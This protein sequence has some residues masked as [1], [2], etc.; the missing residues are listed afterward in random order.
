MVAAPTYSTL[1]E[2]DDLKRSLDESGVKASTLA[3]N[4][5]LDEGPVKLDSLQRSRCQKAL[6]RWQGS[7][8]HNS[9]GAAVRR[10]PHGLR[11]DSAGGV[12]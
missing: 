2:T 4:G 9:D 6:M 3:V 12:I 1:T 11:F 7:I 10:G 8:P 5:V